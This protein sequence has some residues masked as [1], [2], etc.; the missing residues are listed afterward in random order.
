MITDIIR[1]LFPEAVRSRVWEGDLP[2]DVDAC[3]SIR[4]S[5]GP[6]GNYFV[7]DQM[8]TPIISITVRNPEYGAGYIDIQ[9]CKTL[10]NSYVDAQVGLSLVGDVQYFGRDDKRRHLWGLTYKA[11]YVAT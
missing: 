7:K 3:I 5:R 2:T 4:E 11:F 9:Q 1:D 8:E 6:H 10:L